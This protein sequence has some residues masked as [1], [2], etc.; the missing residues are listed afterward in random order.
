VQPRLARFAALTLGWNIVV[1]LWGAYVRA[2]GSGAGCGS[3]WPLCNGEVV[4]RAPAAATLIEL[5]HRLTSGVALVLVVILAVWCFRAA[6]RR[7]P[8]RRSAIASLVLILVEAAIGAG[9]VLLDLV[10]TN[11][12]AVRAG[13]MAVH[14][15]NTFFLLAAL[16]L[17]VWYARG[18]APMR[19]DAPRGHLRAALAAVLVVGATGG[20]AALGDTLFPATSLAAGV[21]DDFA[22]NAHFLLRLRVLHPLMAVAA[23]AYLVFLP[24]LV[25]AAR[26][27]R[28]ARRLGG[29]VALLSLVQLA[30]GSLNI[31]LLA[32][33]WMQLLHLLLADALWIALVLFAAAIRS[34][35]PATQPRRVRGSDA[36]REVEQS[37]APG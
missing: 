4:P 7:H 6:P 24:Q 1:I 9:L 14:L 11:A 29:A 23:G 30:A 35:V 2:T 20:I 33:V 25:D 5:T 21:R 31:V 16:A 17:T 28:G 18:G 26:H 37:A 22:A 13:Y 34:T 12:S 27:G 8:L 3:H 32:P 10:G 19:P 36:A 15:L